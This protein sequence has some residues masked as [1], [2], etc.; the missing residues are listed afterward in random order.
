MGQAAGLAA[1]LATDGDVRGI[2]IRRLQS[3]LAAAGAV[4][5]PET[6]EVVH[7]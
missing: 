3:D 6:Q 1:S 5:A 2:S 4:I 7:V